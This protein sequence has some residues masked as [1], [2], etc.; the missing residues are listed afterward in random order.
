MIFYKI[1]TRMNTFLFPKPPLTLV[2]TLKKWLYCRL[3]SLTCTI[4]SKLI[5]IHKT[6]QSCLHFKIKALTPPLLLLYS[7]FLVS[8]KSELTTI[9]SHPDVEPGTAV[10]VTLVLPQ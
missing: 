8:L 10:G 9:I 6:L 2:L 5:S 7:D 1:S 3:L 4:V